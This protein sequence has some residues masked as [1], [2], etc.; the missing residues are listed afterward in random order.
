[1]ARFLNLNQ[2]RAPSMAPEF[3]NQTRTDP[4]EWG[5]SLGVALVVV[6]SALRLL[7]DLRLLGSGNRQPR[8]MALRAGLAF[9]AGAAVG[10]AAPPMIRTLFRSPGKVRVAMDD[11]IDRDSEDSFPAS[12]PPQ[13]G[14]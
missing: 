3:S 2:D 1:M 4:T 11:A 7:S 6:S 8:S 10:L 5:R 12:D 14:H 13:R 9:A